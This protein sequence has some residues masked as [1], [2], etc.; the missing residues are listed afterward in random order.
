MVR[1]GEENKR[2]T[3]T[4]KEQSET[5]KKQSKEVEEKKRKTGREGGGSQAG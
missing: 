5:K 2:I 3:R 1:K 4:G